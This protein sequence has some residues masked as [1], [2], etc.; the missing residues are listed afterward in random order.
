MKQRDN[1][2]L[3]V[4]SDLNLPGADWN[5]MLS[6]NDYELLLL[7][8]FE[9]HQRQQNQPFK[10]NQSLDVCLTQSPDSIELA[11]ID[12]KITRVYSINGQTSSDHQTIRTTIFIDISATKPAPKVKDAYHKVDWKDFNSHIRDHHFSPYCLSNVDELVDQWYLWIQKIIEILI[13]RVIQQRANL[14]SRISSATSHE[15]KILET[16]KR[17]YERVPTLNLLI[18]IK[19]PKKTP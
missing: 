10:R 11:E 16:M 12:K 14:P 15:L 7:N 19:R 4:S 3:I 1:Y 13:P 17:K 6:D 8:N 9:T 5:S 18:K 2:T